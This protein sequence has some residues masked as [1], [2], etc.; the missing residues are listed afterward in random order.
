MFQI[1][2]RCPNGIVNW[3]IGYISSGGESSIERRLEK[4]R[5]EVHTNGT[6]WLKE[7]R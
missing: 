2:I 1:P 7:K 5:M 4:S 3:I 6:H